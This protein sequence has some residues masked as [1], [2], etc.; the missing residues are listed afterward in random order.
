MPTD[1]WLGSRTVNAVVLNP[2]ADSN[3]AVTILSVALLAK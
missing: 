3:S 1:N 2:D